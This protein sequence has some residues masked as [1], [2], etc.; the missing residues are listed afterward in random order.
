MRGK[1]GQPGLVRQLCYAF[2]SRRSPRTHR[3]GV[4]EPL[5]DRRLLADN[6]L[7][8]TEFLASNSAGLTDE[9]GELSDWIEVQNT[10][11]SPLSLAGFALTDSRSEPTQWRFP[12][13][14]LGAGEYLVVFAS[15]KDRND[16][17][18]PLHTNFRL[19]DEGEYLGL[20][21]PDGTTV[22]QQFNPAFPRQRAGVSYGVPQS[23]TTEV[24]A[25]S[26]APA[27]LL[28][29]TNG[30]LGDRWTSISF[31][32]TS[33]QDA[34]AAVGYDQAANYDALIGSDLE[35][36]LFDRQSSAYLRVPFHGDGVDA[37]DFLHLDMKYDDG[38]VAYLNG[39]EVARRNAPEDTAWNSAASADHSGVLE[40]LAYPTFTGNGLALL[41]STQIANGRLRLTSGGTEQRGTAWTVAPAQFSSSY[42]FSTEFAFEISAPGGPTDNQDGPGGEG[43]T[44]TI[45]STGANV[46]GTNSTAFG[47]T[48]GVNT[49]QK[50]VSVEFDTRPGGIWDSTRSSGSHLGVNHHASV[51]SINQSSRLPRFNDG[52]RHY[53][54]IDYDGLSKQKSVL[55]HDERET[56]DADLSSARRHERPV[57]RRTRAHARFLGLEQQRHERP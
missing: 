51:A 24:L 39:V 30:A 28:V 20:V 29:P 26:D 42:S 48:G 57:Q 54:W 1:S 3:L 18:G 50:F 34:V 43:L 15:G 47:L 37:I 17:V 2:E 11:F 40:T 23:A 21:A 14:T 52:G 41:G 8:I 33:W 44:F 38:F 25:S 4:V 36:A 16:D 31:D 5:E 27:T 12:E 19:S 49:V 56:H 32:D 7:V 9:D 10:D 46:L 35:G 55:L 53:A 6:G 22:L 45:Q 13:V